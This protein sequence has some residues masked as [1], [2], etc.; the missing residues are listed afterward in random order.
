MIK[1]NQSNLDQINSS[2]AK[3]KYD[4]KKITPGIVHIGCG[5]FHRAHQ[6]WYLD[7]LFQKGMSMEF[8]IVGAGVR[9]NDAD[10][11]NKLKNQDW[12]TTLISL[13]ATEK[14]AEIVGS[15]IDY[16]P[17]EAGNGPLIEC[18]SGPE[19]KIV[20]LTVTEGG[21][22][23]NPATK[24]FDK[25]HPDIQHDANYPD[26]P[27]TAFGA[28]VAALKRRREAGHGP[29]TGLCCDNLQGNGDVLKSTVVGL[30]RMSDHELADWI[31]EN[32]T[33]PNSMVDCIV[34]ATGPKEMALVHGFGVDDAVPVTHEPFRQWVIEDKFCAGRPEWEKVGAT[35]SNHVHDF[36]LMK[37]RVLNGGHQVLAMISALLGIEIM[38]ETMRDSRV[39]PFFRKCQEQEI[40]PHVKAVPGYTGLEYLELIDRRFRNPSIVDTT[41]RNCFDGASRQAGFIL[42]SVRD[43]LRSGTPIE[44]LALVSAA[45][46]RYCCGTTEDGRV[47]EPNDPIWNELHGRAMSSKNNPGVW[48]ENHAIY[49]ELGSNQRFSEAFCRWLNLIHSKGVEVA[50]REYTK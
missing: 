37:I 30:A 46:A 17:V 19:I 29:F 43:G 26:E 10:M 1:L 42:P 3:P 14:S 12:L 31:N 9:S 32:C 18:M 36:E 13:G 44:G 4:R 45:W 28:I 15:M 2:V 23:I 38:S 7:Q 40:V 49:G 50:L 11:R 35:F 20:A 21:Y 16:V 33:F 41:R 25:S 24:E 47:I 8:G 6:S 34:P 27:I 5:N 22:F 39:Y 48:L